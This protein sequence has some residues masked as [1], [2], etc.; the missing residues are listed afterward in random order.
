MTSWLIWEG[1]GS[2]DAW[3]LRVIRRGCP[4][5]SGWMWGLPHLPSLLLS[6][7]RTEP[8]NDAA[9]SSSSRSDIEARQWHS[10]PWTWVAVQPG[11]APCGLKATLPAAEIYSSFFC[12]WEVTRQ[13]P[14]AGCWGSML[15]PI[16]SATW[17]CCCSMYLSTGR[18]WGFAS[19]GAVLLCENLPGK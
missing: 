1:F 16:L 5:C 14:G 13:P 6:H 17:M 10:A 12:V 19:G 7:F 2:C 11:W 4:R 15:L 3:H 8:G 18:G 9:R